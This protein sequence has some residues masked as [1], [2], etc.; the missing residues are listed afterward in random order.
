MKILY[1]VYRE[2]NSMVF[3]S[4]VLE[5]LRKLENKGYEVELVVFRNFSNL[6]KKEKVESYIS[7]FVGNYKTFSSY[8]IVS[9]IQLKISSL[10]LRKYLKKNYDENEKILV[11]CRGELA[12][13]T[14][15]KA[16]NDFENSYVVFDNRGL[17]IEEADFIKERK[18]LSSINKK[19]KLKALMYARDNSNV[20]SFVTNNL[21]EFLIE[22]Y[23]FDELKPHFIVPTLAKKYELDN[24]TLADV[25]T[26]INHKDTDLYMIYIGSVAAWQDINKLFEVFL[27][28]RKKVNHIKLIILSDGNVVIPQSF[29]EELLESIIIRSVDHDKVKY[30]LNLSHVGLVFR[31]KTIVNKVAAPTKVAEYIAANV[32]ILYSGDIGVIEDL[33]KTSLFISIDEKNWEDNLAEIMLKKEKVH[34]DINIKEYFDM[35]KNQDYFIR[36]IKTLL[37][38]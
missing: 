33:A 26:S 38:S 22:T 17:P 8:P 12:T 11:L 23:D 3:R 16:F 28:I 6:L 4:Q 2:E 25:K 30:Y 15:I 24:K 19:V 34:Y 35:D 7:S 1:L 37:N 21:R 13:Y 5:Y 27:A 29:S 10:K 32:P 31:D 20:Y 14:A 9:E 18:L 36:E